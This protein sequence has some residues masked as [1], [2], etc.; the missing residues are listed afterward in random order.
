MSIALDKGNLKSIREV[1]TGHLR[2][3]TDAFGVHATDLA[4][5]TKRSKI[6]FNFS[7]NINVLCSHIYLLVGNK[8]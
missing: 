1:K 7:L 5:N 3:C 4:T 2:G 8:L 6:A